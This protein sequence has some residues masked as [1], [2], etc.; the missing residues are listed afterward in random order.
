MIPE[1]PS[2]LNQLTLAECSAYQKNYL[3][4]LVQAN[5]KLCDLIDTSDRAY[6][7]ERRMWTRDMDSSIDEALQRAREINSRLQI[8]NQRIAEFTKGTN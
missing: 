1:L 6:K 5:E 2:N 8:I 7:D 3:D 4:L